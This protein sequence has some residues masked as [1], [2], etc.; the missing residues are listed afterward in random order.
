MS[1]DP[2]TRQGPRPPFARWVAYRRERIRAELA[3]DRV[4]K[5]IE[6]M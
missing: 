3:D 6:S 2:G 1:T 5:L 4:E